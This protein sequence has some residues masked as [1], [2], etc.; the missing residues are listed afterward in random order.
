VAGRNRTAAN[1]IELFN[2]NFDLNLFDVVNVTVVVIMLLSAL[3]LL[4]IRLLENVKM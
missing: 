3:L 4:F 2:L 1:I